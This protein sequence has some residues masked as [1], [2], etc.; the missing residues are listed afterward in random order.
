MLSLQSKSEILNK[1]K[2]IKIDYECKRLQFKII[3]DVQT[4]WYTIC[5]LKYLIKNIYHICLFDFIDALFVYSINKFKKL[6]RLWFGQHHQ[7]YDFN[8]PVS[9]F[10][11]TNERL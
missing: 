4:A 5:L 2:I 11:K 10:F 6:A 7:F 8:W 1:I 3:S 9:I